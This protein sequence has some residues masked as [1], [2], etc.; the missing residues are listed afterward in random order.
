MARLAKPAPPC[1]SRKG[2]IRF[3]ILSEGHRASLETVQEHGTIRLYFRSTNSEFFETD[4][5]PH[6]APLCECWN[7]SCNRMGA[8]VLRVA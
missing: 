5:V 6:A 8:C 2:M 7:T 4:P 1:R 3:S